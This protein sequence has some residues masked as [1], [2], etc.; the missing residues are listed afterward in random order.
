M[1]I[2][3]VEDTAVG[4]DNERLPG[5]PFGQLCD[6]SENAFFVLTPA[7]APWRDVV[8][9]ATDDSSGIVRITRLDFSKGQA[10]ATAKMTFAQLCLQVF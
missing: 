7:F 4:Y 9:V 3:D 8:R 6:A 5:V 1:P 10:L 2:D